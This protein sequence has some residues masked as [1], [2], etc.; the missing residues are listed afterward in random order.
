MITTVR[1][2]EMHDMYQTTWL[3]VTW[4]NHPSEKKYYVKYKRIES[5][6]NELASEETDDDS[7]ESNSQF[8]V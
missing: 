5:H 4:R 8:T 7:I 3:N 2:V 1:L 6:S